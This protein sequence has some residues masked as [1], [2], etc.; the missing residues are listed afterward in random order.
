VSSAKD[1]IDGFLKNMG[2]TAALAPT[3]MGGATLW[4]VPGGV[5]HNAIPMAVALEGQT[6]TLFVQVAFGFVPKAN[7]APLF[8]RLLALNLTLIEGAFCL[9]EVTN[10]LVVQV[11][12]RAEHLEFADFKAI[13][14]GLAAKHYQIA[15]P[16]VHEFQIPQTAS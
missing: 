13:L 1:K 5:T 11:S 16:L 3:S 6:G 8:R 9:N 15:A 7:V 2:F 10:A 14:D 4:Q 12:R